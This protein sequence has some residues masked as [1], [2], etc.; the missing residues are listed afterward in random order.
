MKNGVK[1]VNA[2]VSV[3][4]REGITMNKL[5]PSQFGALVR[6]SKFNTTAGVGGSR[7][8]QHYINFAF[9]PDTPLSQRK[10]F[11]HQNENDQDNL[12]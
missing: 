2:N 1:D 11:F 10:D 9:S 6:I 5:D 7:A 3:R 4:N 8:Q 12:P